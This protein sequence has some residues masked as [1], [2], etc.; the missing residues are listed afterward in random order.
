MKAD[1]LSVH[2]SGLLLFGARRRHSVTA[3]PVVA[4]SK[5]WNDAKTVCGCAG[6]T[7]RVISFDGALSVP[8]IAAA[9]RTKYVP[10]A[11]PVAVK[12]VVVEPVEKFARFDAPDVDPA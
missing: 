2:V 12:V 3:P 10:A 5:S 1:A 8:G 11:T 6:P 9:T 7:V 4:G